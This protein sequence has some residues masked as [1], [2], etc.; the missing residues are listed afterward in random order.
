[1]ETVIVAD[2]SRS[3]TREVKHILK[4]KVNVRTA[5]SAKA[6]EE[7]L[8]LERPAALI[9]DLQLPGLD[10]V[11]VLHALG[12]SETPPKVL[13]I[14]CFLGDCLLRE[15]GIT[16]LLTRPCPAS[17][18]AESVLRMIRQKGAGV[19]AMLE[20]FSVPDGIRGFRYLVKSAQLYRQAG[21][22]K[23]IQWLY[24]QVASCFDTH[25]TLVERNIR[26]AILRG[27]ERGDRHLWQKHFPGGK[28]TNG[29]FIAFLAENWNQSPLEREDWQV[30]NK[31]GNANIL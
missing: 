4:K 21:R 2:A 31:R 26:H 10:A 1:M 29:A 7:L 28:P 12:R 14:T 20:R 25:W 5:C 13:G 18:A 19:A 8:K 9:L 22:P 16:Y 17:V 11:G 30:E 24:P 6:L 3:F 15:P 23:L 27:W